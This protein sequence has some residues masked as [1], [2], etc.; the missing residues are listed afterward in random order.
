[1]ITENHAAAPAPGL[2][3]D[4]QDWLAQSVARG[5]IDA[6]LLAA[7]RQGGF[8]DAYARVAIAVVRSMTERVQAQSPA[9]LDGYEADPIRLP[10]QVASI[11]LADREVGIGFTLQDPNVAL[12][13]DFLSMQECDELI[14]LSQGR[15][16]RS[17][18]VDGDTGVHAM[19]EA[20]TSEGTH[21]R[22]AENPL[23]ERIERRIQALTGIPVD[24]GEGIQVMRYGPGAEY[25]PHHDY[26]DP[27]NPGSAAHLKTGGQR[28]ATLVMYLSDVEEGGATVFPEL[29]L[30][31]KARKGAAAY[32]EFFNARGE[33]DRRLLHAGAEVIRGQK[34]IATKWLRQSTYG[35]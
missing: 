4:W 28:V 2:S 35:Q 31:I 34:W 6:D 5:C 20:R 27:A 14:G 29:D 12:L 30:S 26:F 23:V 8:E 33:V 25:K 13:V 24:H 9:L 18:V 16:S 11:K 21:F 3:P 22:R 15:L 17:R 32:F 1:M 10:T 7:M 19:H